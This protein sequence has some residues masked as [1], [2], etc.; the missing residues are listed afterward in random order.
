MN[1]ITA[2]IFDFGDVLV[3]DTSKEFQNRYS[4]AWTKKQAAAFSRICKLDDLNKYT[5]E[6]H[7]MALQKEVT[8]WVSKNQIKKIIT[9]VRLFKN[10]WSLANRLTKKY[11]VLILSNNSKNGP[12]FIARKLKINYKNIA[13]INSSKIGLRKPSLKIYRYTLKKYGLKPKQTVLVDDK[14]RNLGPAK[15][16]GI[17]TYQYKKDYPNLIK[18]LRQHKI[19]V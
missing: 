15:H 16:L 13:F 17:H 5:V 7:C 4:A 2:I 3:S 12:E 8:P 18:F 14:K 19:L 6:K 10:T 11:R 9:S 1:K